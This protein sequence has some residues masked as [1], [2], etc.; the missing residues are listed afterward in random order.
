MKSMSTFTSEK[1]LWNRQQPLKTLDNPVV[2][3][4]NSAKCAHSGYA[5]EPSERPSATVTRTKAE[6]GRSFT[7]E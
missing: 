5:C 3:V 4:H 7:H 6:V 2:Q 1:S